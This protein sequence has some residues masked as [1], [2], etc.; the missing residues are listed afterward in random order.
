MATARRYRRLRKDPEL[1]PTRLGE[2]S[3]SELVAICRKLGFLTASRAMH[4]DDLISL[5]R[6]EIEAPPDLLHEIRLKTHKK[7]R[8]KQ[9]LR[10]VMNCDL[11]CPT[12]PH[13]K[14]VQCYA[15]NHDR[16]D[17]I[18]LEEP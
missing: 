6:M 1:D 18:Q 5:A 9:L 15:I 13:D 7:V 12:C 3:D 14:V 16:V 17:P 4:R 10:T 8:G 11:H 2:C